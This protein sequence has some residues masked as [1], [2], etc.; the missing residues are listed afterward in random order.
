M[1]VYRLEHR[2]SGI[3]IFNAFSRYIATPGEGGT[4]NPF[5]NPDKEAAAFETFKA[6]RN[7]PPPSA[8]GL[9]HVAYDWNYR[10]AVAAPA[11]LANWFA[12]KE[13][14]H[15]SPDIVAAEYEV[16]ASAVA[17]GRHQVAYLADKAYKV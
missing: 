12:L 3:G 10:Y 1:K 11:Q 17:V 6:T 4:I 9:S 7:T 2:E 13:L 8:D 5:W 14:A 16:P 15:S